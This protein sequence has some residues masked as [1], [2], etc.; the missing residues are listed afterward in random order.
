LIIGSIEVGFYARTRMLTENI[1]RDAAR[2][3]AA[4]GGNY[5]PRTNTTGLAVDAVAL[6]SLKNG[7]HCKLSQCTA[8]PAISCTKV[9]SAAGGV[10][11]SN[12]VN[13]AGETVTCVITYKY[14]PLAPSLMDGPLGLGIGTILKP[15]TVEESARAETGTL[16]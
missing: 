13:Y 11:T 5:N 4:D 9:T 14:K 12:T 8:L 16:G 2:Q 1:A 10:Y 15:F 3:V 7:S 6:R